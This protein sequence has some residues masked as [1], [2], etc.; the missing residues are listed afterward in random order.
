MRFLIPPL[1][2]LVAGL[3]VAVGLHTGYVLLGS[4]FRTALPGQVY[5][6]A[7]PSPAALDR[8][9]RRHG[10]RTVVNLR[11]CCP[12]APWYLAEARVTSTLDVA[13]E[14][15]SFSATR[16]PSRVPMQHLLDVLDRSAY[17][18]LLHCHQGADRT[19][20]AAVLARLLRTDATLDQALGQLGL[21]GGHL[22]FGKT[23]HIDRFFD[24][25]RDWLVGHDL[26]HSP[27]LLR[28]YITSHYCPADGRA[29]FVV[30][31][32]LAERD[33]RP[34]LR[35]RA[36]VAGPVTVRCHNRS[37]EPWV[38]QPG[39]NAGVHV[40]WTLLDRD[41]RVLRMDRAGL[42]HARVAPGGFIDVVLPLTGM[43]PGR[44][45]LRVDLVNEQHAAFAQLGNDLLVV[46][47]EVS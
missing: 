40:W 2:G 46:E 3:L 29:E 25:Y 31:E 44:Y 38:F 6:C 37:L 18:I 20:L 13:Q 45:E 26:A 42:Y 21:A 28:A 22:S 43:A 16:L 34:L 32:T 8:I 36:G 1:R 30:Q 11:G 4:N 5:R 14:D 7:Q 17:P 9:L 41:E 23:G 15:V 10:I 33:G 39:N 35:R 27:A 19:G 24:L 47:V 12:T